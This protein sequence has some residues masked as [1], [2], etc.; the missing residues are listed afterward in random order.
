MYYGKVICTVQ[1]DALSIQ[2]DHNVLCYLFLPCLFP[3]FL[4]L[5]IMLINDDKYMS[6][7]FCCQMSPGTLASPWRW[8]IGCVSLKTPWVRCWGT[9]KTSY[10]PPLL[11]QA[12][13]QTPTPDILWVSGSLIVLSP[14]L[15][16]H[17]LF[18]PPL[19]EYFLITYHISLLEKI[20]S[21]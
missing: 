6:W 3:F 2:R 4:L 12:P 20:H 15:Y 17:V 8:T 18:L 19:D 10:L 9:T 5:M 1:I 11:H 13:P 14:L 21:G 16:N 7:Y